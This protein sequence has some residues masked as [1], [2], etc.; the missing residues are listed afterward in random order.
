MVSID[1]KFP[2]SGRNKFPGLE[3][4][5]LTFSQ[6]GQFLSV[7]DGSAVWVWDCGRLVSL[8][9]NSKPVSSKFSYYYNERRVT[10]ENLVLFITQ[11]KSF[12]WQ[13]RPTWKYNSS[14]SVTRNQCIPVE[15]TLR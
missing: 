2:I 13:C 9:E 6:C 15:K 10:T 11:E 1:W 7:A 12:D 4:K 8:I 14:K 5:L 3:N